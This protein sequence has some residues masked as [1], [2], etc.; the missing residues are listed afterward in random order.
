MIRLLA[1]HPVAGEIGIMLFMIRRRHEHLD[2]L[3]QDL[4]GRVSEK[5]LTGRVVDVN[6]A[7]HVDD[8]DAV[9]SGRDQRSNRASVSG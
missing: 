7:F 8:D 6:R 4:F 9:D 1:R 3:A 2:V 5:A